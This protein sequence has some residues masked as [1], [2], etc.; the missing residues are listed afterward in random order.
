MIFFVSFVSKKIQL[1]IRV[2]CMYSY[3]IKTHFRKPRRG[4]KKYAEMY[5]YRAL[6]CSEISWV[7]VDEFTEE[8]S[9]S[10][11]LAAILLYLP[12]AR[13]PGNHVSSL[14]SPS[15]RKHIQI[16]S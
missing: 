14:L 7:E 11:L 12:V 5:D 16:R 15:F 8:I 10:L 6:C 3:D 13:H 2:Q 9:W 4:K 1:T